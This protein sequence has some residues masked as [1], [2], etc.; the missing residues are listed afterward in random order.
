MRELSSLNGNCDGLDVAL[1]EKTVDFGSLVLHSTLRRS[2]VMRSFGELG[3][4]YKWDIK[5]TAP[6]FTI[7]PSRGYIAA[8]GDV[9]FEVTFT[10]NVIDA[11]IRVRE[12]D[13]EMPGNRTAVQLTV[14]GAC[15]PL[16]TAKETVTF[17]C[18]VRQTDV[19]QLSV[20]NTTSTLWPLR[21]V[22][23]NDRWSVPPLVTVKPNATET[24]DA[25]FRPLDGG[26]H[27]GMVSVLLPTGQATV[28][29][30][31]GKTQP[32]RPNGKIVRD[33]P[34]RTVC[35]LY[36]SALMCILSKRHT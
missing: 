10:P 33:I 1:Q 6:H 30:L 5:R 2:I 4:Y 7:K 14:I 36:F 24:F 23:N 32:P 28:F 9:V 21:P 11:D 34:C 35:D 22:V 15:V 12:I 8:K 3:T 16:P 20:T 17:E 31:H 29:N 26:P 19:K 25:V 18:P 27:V 13:C